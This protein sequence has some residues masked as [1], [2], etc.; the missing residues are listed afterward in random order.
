MHVRRLAALL[1][2]AWLAMGGFVALVAVHNMEAVDNPLIAPPRYAGLSIEALGETTARTFLRFY[3]AELSRWY[4]ETWE[5]AQLVLGVWLLATLIA[6]GVQRRSI[7]VLC[8]LM[9]VTVLV[10]HFAVAPEMNRLGRALDFFPARRPTPDRERVAAFQRA[11]AVHRGHESSLRTDAGLQ[12]PAPAWVGNEGRRGE[13]PPREGE[14]TTRR[15]VLRMTAGGVAAPIA[16]GAQNRAEMTDLSA[17]HP[18]TARELLA[19]YD[20]WAARVGVVM[21]NEFPNGPA[22]ERKN[23]KS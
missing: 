3:S 14:M 19:K 9:L 2:G 17:M 16:R 21:P 18:E 12:P 13:A 1:S 7:V 5:L 23:G 4:L 10:L 8:F 6:G 22:N 15:E 20:A 11:Y